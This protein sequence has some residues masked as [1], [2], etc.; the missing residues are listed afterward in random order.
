MTNTEPVEAGTSSVIGVDVG[1]SKI[2]ARVVDPAT[3]AAR[4]R[5]KKNTPTDG[6]G[7]VVDAIVDSVRALDGWADASAIGVGVPGPVT[8][9]GT[10]GPCPNIVGWDEPVQVATELAERFG[11]PVVVSND[12]NC[13]AVAEHRIGSGRGHADM[14]A[15]FVGTG[16]GGGLILDNEL[17]VGQRGMVGEI[18]H[19][20]VDPGGRPCGCGGFGHLETYAGRAGI[21]NEMRRR[22]DANRHLLSQVGDSQL[23]SRHIAAGLEAG[24]ELSAQLIEEAA[25]ALALVIGNAA[26][27][28]DLPLVVL[29]GGIVDRL[30]EPFLEQI[31]TSDDFGG[32]GVDFTE[33]VLARRLDDAG[34]VGAAF[35]VADPI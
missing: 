11:K 27:L 31:R 7:A 21:D 17:I 19:L 3:G 6:P 34:A 26:T 15:I 29:G 13:G 22:T 18:G 35:L 30:G 24:D 33:L 9:D 28:L 10:A 12:V 20:T 16:V 14:L 4:G 8:P 32:V 1:G 2:L 25:H 5:V 23:K